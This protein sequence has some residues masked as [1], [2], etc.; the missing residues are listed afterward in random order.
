[1]LINRFGPAEAAGGGLIDEFAACVVADVPLLTTVAV[2]HHA[3]WCRFTG[4]GHVELAHHA[5]RVLDWCLAQ[6]RA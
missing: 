3:N 4:N 2:Q 1:M 5:R 6:H